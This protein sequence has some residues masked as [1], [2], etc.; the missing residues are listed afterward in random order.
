M[1]FCLYVTPPTVY[2]GPRASSSLSDTDCEITLVTIF[3][4]R[5]YHSNI[6]KEQQQSREEDRMHQREREWNRPKALSRSVTPELHHQHSLEFHRRHSQEIPWTSPSHVKSLLNG[7]TSPLSGRSLHR[8]DSVASLRSFDDDRSSRSGSMSSQADRKRSFLF[9]SH[10]F[11]G[12]QIVIGWLSLTETATSSVN[13]NG[14]NDTH[15]PDRLQVLAR[16]LITPTLTPVD[17]HR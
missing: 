16:I 12:L 6:V 10:R 9:T 1:L 4:R 11:N 13:E 2:T 14:I 7:V 3:S 5:A 15:R 8:R 17:L